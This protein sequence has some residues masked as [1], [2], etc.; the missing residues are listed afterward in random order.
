VRRT[1]Q[2]GDDQR[3]VGGKKAEDGV[4]LGAFER[5]LESEQGRMV[6]ISLWPLVPSSAGQPDRERPS[7]PMRSGAQLGH[8]TAANTRERHHSTG[9]RPFS[10]ADRQVGTGRGSAPAAAAVQAAPCLI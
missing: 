7:P 2:A 5:R 8:Q 3:R 10:R 9:H 4:D 1:E 6:T